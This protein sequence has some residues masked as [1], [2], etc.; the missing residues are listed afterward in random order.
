MRLFPNKFFLWIE[1]LIFENF[2]LRSLP[3]VRNRYLPMLPLTDHVSMS[4]VIFVWVG[5]HMKKNYLFII[6]NDVIYEAPFSSFLQLLHAPPLPSNY[7][8]HPEHPFFS[9]R[10]HKPRTSN[11]LATPPGFPQ[12]IRKPLRFSNHSIQNLGRWCE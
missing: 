3:L 9:D 2:Y 4:C 1:S 5:L 7:D 10:K 12:Q 8:P 6:K 11:L